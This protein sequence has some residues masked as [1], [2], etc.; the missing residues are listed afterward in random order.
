MARSEDTGGYGGD[1]GRS[2]QIAAGHATYPQPPRASRGTPRRENRGRADDARQ[3]Q[4][5]EYFVSEWAEIVRALG[6]LVMAP[7]R[8]FNER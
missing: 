8:R 5:D 4:P 3:S 1:G 6:T 2:R 7:R